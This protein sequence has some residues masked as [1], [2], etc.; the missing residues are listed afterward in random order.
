MI[1]ENVLRRMKWRKG[2]IEKLIPG[3][4]KLIRGAEIRIFQGKLGKTLVTKRPIQ[5]LVPLEIYCA[6]EYGNNS[7]KPEQSDTQPATL[8]SISKTTN[9][10]L[11]E[12][13]RMTLT[14]CCVN[15]NVLL[16]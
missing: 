8:I 7:A 14:G 1:K 12:I 4:D 13:I 15:L 6:D 11:M 10:I 9:W 3:S 16:L 5:L 2:R